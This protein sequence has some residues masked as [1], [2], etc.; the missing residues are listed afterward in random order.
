M[1]T[2]KEVIARKGPMSMAAR[3]AEHEGFLRRELATAKHRI[4][5]QSQQ[6]QALRAEV[7]KWQAKA[8]GGK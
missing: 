6:I 7:R 1:S 3:I 4:E 5:M 2:P 8:G